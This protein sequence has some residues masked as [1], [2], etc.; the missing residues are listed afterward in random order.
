VTNRLR[1]VPAPWK[2]RADVLEACARLYAEYLPEGSEAAR[3]A[4]QA[5]IAEDS[6]KA[7]ASISA[8][9]QLINLEAREGEWL[10]T[11]GSNRNLDEAQRLA[12]SAVKRITALQDL[13]YGA[14]APLNVERQS[15]FG[16]AYKRAAAV[17][18]RAGQ[19]WEAAEASLKKAREAY[20]RGE[21]D[22]SVPGWNPYACLNRLQLDAVLG[23]N[24]DDAH[25]LALARCELAAR[26]RFATTYDF[27]DAVMAA[28]TAV[29]EWLFDRKQPRSERAQDDEADRLLAVYRGALKE[30]PA[31]A[32]QLDSVV[33]QLQLVA[34]F[35]E[36][37]GEKVAKSD[38]VRSAVLRRLAGQLGGMVDPGRGPSAGAA[39]SPDHS[40]EAANDA[41]SDEEPGS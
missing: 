13:T 24:A 35:L 30:L 22:P 12:L 23:A 4:F 14:S 18:L 17:A 1:K 38:R 16:S 36:V 8:I 10:S 31:T 29:T 21:G 28:D 39:A 7:P 6:W 34:E 37:R 15:I 5:A 33:T 20:V 32:R 19:G 11:P 27:W 2:T 9:E 41:Q 40:G 26:S 25:Q 3:L